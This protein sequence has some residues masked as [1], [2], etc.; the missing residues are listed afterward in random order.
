[1]Q[2]TGDN[3]EKENES[4]YA[5]TSYVGDGGTFPSNSRKAV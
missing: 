5:D 2:H 4:H 3:Y 1:M